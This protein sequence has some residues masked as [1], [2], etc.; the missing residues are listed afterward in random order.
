[1]INTPTTPL[2]PSLKDNETLSVVTFDDLEEAEDPLFSLDSTRLQQKVK[3]D[4]NSLT[5]SELTQE[6]TSRNLDVTGTKIQKLERLER[7]L[8]ETQTVKEDP[9]KVKKKRQEKVAVKDAPAWLKQPRDTFGARTLPP[10]W[11]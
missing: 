5:S 3:R 4:T 9:W 6:L 1:V 2:E 8:R 7:Y 10:G 11:R